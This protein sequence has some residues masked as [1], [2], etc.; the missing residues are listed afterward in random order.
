MHIK[1]QQN[2]TI[3]IVINITRYGEINPRYR[4]KYQLKYI[5]IKMLL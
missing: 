3:E 2:I 1:S 5:Q 4:N